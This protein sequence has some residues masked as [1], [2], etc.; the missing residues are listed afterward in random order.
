MIL[1]HQLFS[2]VALQKQLNISSSLRP[3]WKDPLL[4]VLYVRV[5]TS[6]RP[7]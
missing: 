3:L 5:L 4:R 2:K 7:E 6:H 1:K